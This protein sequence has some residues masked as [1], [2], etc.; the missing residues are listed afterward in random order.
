MNKVEIET[1]I[2]FCRESDISEQTRRRIETS[3][4]IFRKQVGSILHRKA[5]KIKERQQKEN[6]DK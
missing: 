5:E 4:R 2:I 3:G 1:E 6:K